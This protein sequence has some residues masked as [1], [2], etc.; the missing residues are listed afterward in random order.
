MNTA[1]AD[2]FGT[3]PT[4]HRRPAGAPHLTQRDDGRP[5]RRHRRP[6]AAAARTTGA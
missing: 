4:P 2:G 5:V 3:S 6:P 1:I